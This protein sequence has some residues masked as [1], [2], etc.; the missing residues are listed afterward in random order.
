MTLAYD[1]LTLTLTI[2]VIVFLLTQLPMTVYAIYRLYLTPE[3]QKNCEKSAFRYLTSIAD[4]LTVVN[5]SVN[6]LIYYPSA[7]TFRR[8]MQQMFSRISFTSSGK[9]SNT[10]QN[11]MTVQQ[12]PPEQENL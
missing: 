6:F 11:Y 2:L 5:S 9:S 3:Q 4:T 10:K 8:T 1:E 12:P 7:V